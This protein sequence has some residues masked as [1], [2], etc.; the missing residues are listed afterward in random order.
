MNE[1]G[2]ND[3]IVVM[4]GTEPLSRETF[5][6]M[7]ASLIP[8]GYTIAMRDP[9]EAER[10]ITGGE[11]DVP[12]PRTVGL[13]RNFAAPYGKPINPERDAWNAAVAA[14]KAEKKAK[15]GLK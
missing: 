9:A 8:A 1:I 13:S 10:L 12:E 4:S 15:K 14:K 5:D 7:M 6:A 2:P 11:G 3:K